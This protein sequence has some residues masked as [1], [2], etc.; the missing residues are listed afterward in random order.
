MIDYLNQ[1]NLIIENFEKIVVDYIKPNSSVL[2]LGCGDGALLEKLKREKNARG[3]GIEI[4]EQNVISC[5]S[6]GLSVCQGNIDDGLID[7]ADKSFDYIIINNTLQQMYKPEFVINEIL[8]VG[9]IIIVGMASFTFW[10]IRLWLL[11]KGKLPKTTF[12]QYEWYNTPN[13]RVISV[14]DFADFARHNNIKIKDFYGSL[15]N[16]FYKL[17]ISI[18][19]LLSKYCIFICE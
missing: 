18:A 8:R 2:D 9:K 3:V 10:K 1:R 7:Y 13:I 11:F 17:P 19:N 6:R 16:N 5:I 15:G 12:Y 14:K 4:N